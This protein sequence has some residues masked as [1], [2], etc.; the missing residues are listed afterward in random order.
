MIVLP[1]SIFLSIIGISVALSQRSTTTTKMFS[2]ILSR[3]QHN[4][5]KT[6]CHFTRLP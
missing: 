5:Q 4:I 2:R 6:K 3:H 1:G